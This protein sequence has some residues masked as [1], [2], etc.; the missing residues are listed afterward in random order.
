MALDVETVKPAVEHG[1]DTRCA[2]MTWRMNLIP[3]M[4]LALIVND[5]GWSAALSV[6][7]ASCKICFVLAIYQVAPSEKESDCM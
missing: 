6:P 2:S 1:D 3:K 4:D 5:K 7:G